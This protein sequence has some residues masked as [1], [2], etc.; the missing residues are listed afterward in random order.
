M[1]TVQLKCLLQL[2]KI[3]KGLSGDGQLKPFMCLLTFYSSR[4]IH[5]SLDK[6][7]IKELHNTVS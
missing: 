2:K 6:V 1:V 3:R 5:L 7:W 4:Q